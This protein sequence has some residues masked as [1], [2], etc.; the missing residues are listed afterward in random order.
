M[1][2][3]HPDK[4]AFA[5]SRRE[6]LC[7]AAAAALARPGRLAA[8]PAEDYIARYVHPDLRGF[9][10]RIMAGAASQPP[11]TAATLPRFRAVL[12][13]PP[14]PGAGAEKRVIPGAQGQP[15][16]TV[17]VVNARP[18]LSR[19]IVLH[20]HGGGFIGGS[21][22][23]A[24][25]ALAELCKALDCVAVTVE[26]RLA[27][28]T[29]FA[30]SIEDNYAALAWLHRHAASLGGDPSRIALLGES[31]GGGHAAL[32]AIT[33]RDRGEVPVAFQCLI[34]PMLDDRTGSTRPVPPHLG[35]IIWT[36]E[37]NRFG[38]RSFLG[39]P[40]GGARVPRA[41][42]PARL[43]DLSGLPPAFVGVGA[44]DLFLDEDI[45]YARRLNDSGVAAELIV[46]PGAYHGFDGM[47]VPVARRFTAA[48]LD[49]LRR[50]LGIGAT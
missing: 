23:S 36:A 43:G 45:T 48:K 16:V 38:W 15:P 9:A 37:Q 25:P 33:A 30:G 22:R 24:V 20:T 2:G 4:P 46:V 49:A 1:T 18:G 42:V 17:Y 8:Q 5:L 11:L 19:P 32:L 47:P 28:E 34:Y 14:P 27:P 44:L 12:D 50:G 40:P 7:G 41:A 26:Y 3:A 35:R 10:R 13:A 29:T 31:A 6:A 21:A 39:M